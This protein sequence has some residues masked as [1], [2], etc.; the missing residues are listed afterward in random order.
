MVGVLGG[1]G[2]FVCPI[3]FGYLLEWT[4]LWTSCWIFMCGLSLICLLWLHLTAQK[5]MKTKH[6][7]DMKKIE[8]DKHTFIDD[9][10][11]E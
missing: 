3:I 8:Q 11:K 6:P 2:G 7:T 4:G 9:A 1:L 10:L 5:L